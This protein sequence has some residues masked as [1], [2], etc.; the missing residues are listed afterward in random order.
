MQEDIRTMIQKVVQGKPLEA[1]ES[2]SKII[3]TKALEAMQRLKVDTAKE[4]YN[5]GQE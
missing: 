3:S 1:Q 2:F 5:K 4:Y